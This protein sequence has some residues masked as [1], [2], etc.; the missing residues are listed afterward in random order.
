MRIVLGQAADL[1]RLLQTGDRVERK[2][3][4]GTGVSLKFEKEAATAREL[5]RARSQLCRGGGTTAT[6][7]LWAIDPR[8]LL[9]GAL[10]VRSR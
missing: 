2:R 7:R 3:L 1:I 6:V 5:V 8:V 4:P 9:A 10:C